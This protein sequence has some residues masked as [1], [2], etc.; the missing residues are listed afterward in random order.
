MIKNK[1]KKI[2]R[3][4]R[5]TPE[6]FKRGTKV[7]F[8]ENTDQETR[9]KYPLNSYTVISVFRGNLTISGKTE[10]TV[11]DVDGDCYGY[12]FSENLEKEILI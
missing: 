3:S 7:K 10:V 12:V 8:K 9:I 4:L 1:S 6:G 11:R 2:I 5:I